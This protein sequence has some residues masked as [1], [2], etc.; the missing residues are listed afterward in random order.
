[1]LLSPVFAGLQA[2]LV[3]AVPVIDWDWAMA[4]NDSRKQTGKSSFIFPLFLVL[5]GS[6]LI[7]ECVSISGVCRAFVTV[8]AC[9]AG[10]AKLR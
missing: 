3:V 2:P 8:C 1:V 7:D 9:R 10:S 4:E 6:I 5:L